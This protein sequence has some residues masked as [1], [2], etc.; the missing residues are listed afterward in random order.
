MAEPL[1]EGDIASVQRLL[2]EAVSHDGAHVQ[3]ADA[4]IQSLEVKDHNI[5]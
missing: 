4:A 3:R 1:G 5:L 2:T